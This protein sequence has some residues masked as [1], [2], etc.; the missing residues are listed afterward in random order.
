M[1]PK[2]HTSLSCNQFTK[3]FAGIQLNCY[4]QSIGHLK[5]STFYSSKMYGGELLLIQL[6]AKLN[7]H[8]YIL[9]PEEGIESPRTGVIGGCE[10]SL[11][12]SL[13]YK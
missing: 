5:F 12:L 3:L 6:I 9:T 2:C 10:L 7:I 13:K 1:A 4:L 11:W 8:T